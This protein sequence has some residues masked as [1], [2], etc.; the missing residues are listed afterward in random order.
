M[1]ADFGARFTSAGLI[2][3]DYPSYE[4][5]ITGGGTKMSV[6]FVTDPD[7]EAV[8]Q[9]TLVINDVTASPSDEQLSAVQA[10]Y[11]WASGFNADAADWMNERLSAFI[12]EPGEEADVEQGFGPHDAGFFGTAL[13]KDLPTLAP[14]GTDPDFAAF[15]GVW[16]EM[17]D[18]RTSWND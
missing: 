2:K 9:A 5:E 10:F 6:S 16:I 8:V 1:G 4:A 13:Y 18:F 3:D 15:G 17:E 7:T 12:S 14:P 11:A